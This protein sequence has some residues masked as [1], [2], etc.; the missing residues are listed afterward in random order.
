MQELILLRHAETCESVPSQDDKDRLLTEH[1]REQATAA[2]A[3]L[4]AHCWPDM[5]LCSPARRTR[6]TLAHVQEAGASDTM[7]THVVDAIYAA[8]AGE[9]IG[10]ID[11]HSQDADRLLLVGHNPGIEH[12]IALLCQGH[13]HDFRGVPA[14]TVAHIRVGDRLEPGHGTLMAFQSF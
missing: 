9:L 7:P 11:A 13:S 8:T 10:I 1:G 6:S 2:G 3:W 12:L 14:A 5:A 4:H